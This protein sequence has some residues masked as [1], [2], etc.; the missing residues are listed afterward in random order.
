MVESRTK[1]TSASS[2]LR[3]M[4]RGRVPGLNM[5]QARIPENSQ[6]ITLPM[7]R[8]GAVMRHEVDDKTARSCCSFARSC[9]LFG[10]EVLCERRSLAAFGSEQADERRPLVPNG[11]QPLFRLSGDD[12]AKW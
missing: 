1:P 5:S 9:C 11:L 6:R 2:I 8:S 4:R 3:A 12:L 7:V 10:D